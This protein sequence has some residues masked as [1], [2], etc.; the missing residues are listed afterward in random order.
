M[1]DTQPPIKPP[2]NRHSVNLHEMNQHQ[3]KIGDHTVGQGH[4]PLVI[5]EAG[6][7]HNGDIALA[8][9]LVDAAANAGADAVKFQAFRAEFLVTPE[10]P[11][12]NY[13]AANT[14]S[15]E[16]Q[17]S[18]LKALELTQADFASLKDQ[19]DKRGILFLCT[20]FDQ[21]SA[22]MIAELGVQAMKIPSGEVT[23]TVFL[24][25]LA[26]LQLPLILST[27]M[28]TLEE[29]KEAAATIRTVA[30]DQKRGEPALVVLH[31]VSSYPAAPSQMNLRVMHTLAGELEVAAGLSDHTLGTHMA[32]A[33]AAMGAAV[34]EKHFTLD[35][36]LPGPDHR[37]SLEPD[38]LAVMVQGIKDVYAGLG[39][40]V[41]AVSSDELTTASLV[42]RSIA[43]AVAIPKGTVLTLEML[44]TL[45]PAGG[46]EPAR[47]DDV[48]GQKTTRDIA[49]MQVL[50][51]S[52]LNV[53]GS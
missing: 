45:R 12:A 38:Q 3:M 35:C 39:D 37:A 8:H 18:M 50:A 53:T 51:W 52:D 6:V 20:P 49:P 32:M 27:G 47:I 19:C 17:F 41:K 23:N 11:R 16:S 21:P 40:G 13:Q 30:K 48:L 4:R 9:K 1:R 10:A 31:C 33:A 25:H 44:M 29:I 42:R 36:S 5:A 24:R 26:K 46:I 7:N 22:D 34:I 28:A 43:A 15:N 14:G 2:T